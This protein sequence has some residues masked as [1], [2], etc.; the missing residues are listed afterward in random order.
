MALKHYHVG[1]PNV[2]VF[3]VLTFVTKEFAVLTF[4]AFRKYLVN[5]NALKRIYRVPINE[6]KEF[7]MTTLINQNNL[8]LL[9]YGSRNLTTTV[10]NINK[11]LVLSRELK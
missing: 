8:T 3:A 2:K 4:M 10:M 6:S 9:C 1:N 7:S 11:F 5:D